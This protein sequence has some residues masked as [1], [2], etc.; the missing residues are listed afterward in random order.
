MSGGEQMVYFSSLLLLPRLFQ[1]SIRGDL[2]NF[3]SS[4]NL[5]QCAGSIFHGCL[6]QSGFW[7]CRLLCVPKIRQALNNGRFRNFCIS[8]ICLTKYL[9]WCDESSVY[10]FRIL[11]SFP[12]ALA[13]GT[14]YKNIRG[15]STHYTQGL[16]IH[17]YL[18]IPT[19]SYWPRGKPRTFMVVAIWKV[20][21]YWMLS[22]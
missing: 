7:S 18:R 1:T 11:L 12:T 14:S 4:T 20:V 21:R 19:P 17:M 16:Y 6:F 3:I 5:A 10:V 22:N 13:R 8:L 15:Y 9:I 2:L